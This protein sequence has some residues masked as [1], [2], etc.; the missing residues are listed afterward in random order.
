MARKKD[1]GKIVS[2]QTAREFQEEVARAVDESRAKAI[3]PLVNLIKAI[4]RRPLSL[5][6]TQIILHAM[7]L[8]NAITSDKGR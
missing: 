2:P 7:D 1:K 3:K 8:L 6:D 5:W 4:K